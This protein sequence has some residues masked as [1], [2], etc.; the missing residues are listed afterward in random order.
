MFFFKKNVQS[1][2][3]AQDTVEYLSSL[4]NENVMKKVEEST[5]SKVQLIRDSNVKEVKEIEIKSN[6]NVTLPVGIEEDL[7]QIYEKLTDMECH[8]QQHE[9]QKKETMQALIK[10][11][12]R[13]QDNQ[14]IEYLN[15]EEYM[16]TESSNQNI[17]Q[18]E[19]EQEDDNKLL[20][21]LY[22]ILY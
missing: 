22:L 10:N 7:K 15:M 21:E 19:E 9:I 2:K 13:N 4:E 16:E 3:E 5:D 18:I 11:N 6:G 1:L 14:Q 17:T 20:P 12:S 8:W